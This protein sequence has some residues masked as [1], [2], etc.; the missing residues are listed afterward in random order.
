MAERAEITLIRS[1]ERFTLVMYEITEAA[2][3]E[4][5]RGNG[6]YFAV[7]LII[8]RL[9]TETNANLVFGESNLSAPGVLKA[10]Y[11]QGRHSTLKNLSLL[12]LTEKPLRQPV[13]I[14]GGINDTRPK[15][16]KN[17]LLVTYLVR[18]E[19]IKKHGR[20]NSKTT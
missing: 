3:R 1:N 12:G 6:L 18:D 19:L 20:P 15:H 8:N 4:E 9:L 5:Y 11:R 7:A 14:S 17:D 16:L 2:T 10:A 13:R